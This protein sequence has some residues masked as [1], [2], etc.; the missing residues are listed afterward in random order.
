MKTAHKIFLAR[1]AYRAVSKIRSMLGKSD[2]LV[3]ERHGVRYQLNLNEGIDFSIYLLKSFEPMTRQAIA[4]I[5]KEGDTV[6]DIGANVGA[7]T[8]TLAKAAGPSG[9]VFAFEPTSYAFRKLTANIELNPDLA[10]RIVALNQFVTAN[11]TDDR[12][13]EIY[14]SWPLVADETA[15]LHDQHL[16]Q[17]MT[18]NDAVS[19]TL[20]SVAQTH[21]I[22]RVDVVKLDVDGFEM[23]VLDGSNGFLE[24]HRPIFI[25]EL[26]PFELI[27]RGGDIDRYTSFFDN[28]GYSYYTESGRPIGKSLKQIVERMPR[29]MSRNIVA[30]V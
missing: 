26:M 28:L 4:R 9:K 15:S 7:H 27:E 2:D 21:G 1:N 10:G 16:G 5:V 13:T 3:C 8:L 12:P 19:S 25:M 18:S 6:L 14:S 22:E 24:R 20:S 23:Q 29:G 17:L 11:D 30:R